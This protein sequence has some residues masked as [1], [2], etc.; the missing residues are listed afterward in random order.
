MKPSL[1]SLLSS[2]LL[3]L[4]GVMFPFDL[5]AVDEASS[6][7]LVDANRALFRDK[8]YPILKENCFKCHGERE[9]LKGDFRVTSREGLIHGGAFGPGYNA[10]EPA[11]SVL[12]KMISYEEEEYQ[13]PPK[14]KL[15]EAAIAT[16]TEW[17]HGGAHYDESLEIQGKATERRGFSVSESDREWW[18]YRPL[19]DETPPGGV[20][21][22]D[23]FVGEKLEESELN[24]N[25]RADPS[26]LV[27]RLFYDLI[28]LPPSPE[29]VASFLAAS[30]VNE[31]KAWFDLVEDLLSRP[32]YGEKW[33]RH[34]LDVVRYAES[35][36]FERDNPKP[37]IWRY[38]DYVIDA[39]NDD[40]PYDQFVLE[41]LAGDEIENPTKQ[42]MIA[43][44]YHRLMQWDDEPADR[45]QHVYDVL[46][47]NVQ[48]TSETFL[49]TTLNCARCHDHKADPISQ[50][51]F[52]SFMAFF[53]GVTHYETA[54]T[55]VSWADPGERKAFE[56][57]RQVSVSRLNRERGELGEKLTD[58]LTKTGDIGGEH[59]AGSVFVS[60]ARAD[61]AQWFYTMKK[62]S[63]DWK[64][65]GFLNKSWY[66]AKG[67]FGAGNPPNS[68]I[69]TEWNLND[70]WMRTTFG[71]T[72]I[73]ETL[74]L[75]IYHDENVEVYLNGHLVYEAM[76]YT[77]GYE[78]VQLFPA[79]LDALQTG[80]NVVAVHCRNS[81]GGQNIDLGLR[82]ES[83]SA[84]L[85][86]L[87]KGRQKTRL[88]EKVKAEFGED[89]LARYETTLRELGSW[90]QRKAGVPLNVVTEKGANPSPMHIHLRGSAH[91]YG[92]EVEPGI[93]AVLGSPDSDP[94]EL[95]A[96]PV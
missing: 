96:N 3:V 19:S 46:A 15:D 77:T 32:Q 1:L 20:N 87:V 8:V 88:R 33:A 26:V 9:H 62:P 12:L 63:D 83:A 11:E 7:G 80:K 89:L 25:E 59:S 73:P 14:G 13:M 74:T 39:F 40:K 51:D 93:P 47:D 72:A 27:R 31:D 41:Q 35:N 17:I 50:K 48:V 43:T 5:G 79:A 16:L 21:G 81:V 95:G 29:E 57:E 36:G 4:G 68:V 60:D 94:L 53:R 55:L 24:Q 49:A 18:A 52:Y 23:H 86:Q 78:T 61:G 64:D 71:L 10:E 76:G 70:I 69:Q 54:G 75:D 45:K 91:A 22:I 37:H 92:E 38:R 82:T 90:R 66:K 85:D 67:G 56:R 65:V 42:S 2:H 30:E 34:W 84:S 44:G 28:G 58:F 6:P